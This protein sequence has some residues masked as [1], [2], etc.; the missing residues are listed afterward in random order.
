MVKARNTLDNT[1]G[2]VRVVG[3]WGWVASCVVCLSG[4]WRTSN[5]TDA[6]MYHDHHMHVEGEHQKT[7]L[8]LF[9]GQHTERACIQAESPE[10]I[11]AVKKHCLMNGSIDQGK[12]AEVI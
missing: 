5:Y 11:I 9:I 2:I 4:A 1:G 12:V 7:V 3:V 10:R 6:F 8:D